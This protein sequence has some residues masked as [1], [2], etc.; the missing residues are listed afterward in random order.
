M[1]KLNTNKKRIGHTK[2]NNSNMVKLIEG[3]HPRH[4]WRPRKQFIK[5]IAE[6]VWVRNYSEMKRLA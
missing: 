3:Q 2:R 5:Q 4:R 6:D 1:V